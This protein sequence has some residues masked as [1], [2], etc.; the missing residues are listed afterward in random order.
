MQQLLQD[1]GRRTWPRCPKLARRRARRNFDVTLSDPI[2]RNRDLKVIAVH[3][4]FH[5][6]TWQGIGSPLVAT[7]LAE[8]SSVA[9][10][11]RRT[12]LGFSAAQRMCYAIQRFNESDAPSLGGQ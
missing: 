9:L 10:S 5:V 7:H 4:N 1:A 6:R 12:R 3:E 8:A 11:L 2:A